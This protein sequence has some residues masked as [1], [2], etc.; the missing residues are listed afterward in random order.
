MRPKKTHFVPKTNFIAAGDARSANDATADTSS[1]SAIHPY[2]L[3]KKEAFSNVIADV[4]A[5]LVCMLK[6]ITPSSVKRA[7]FPASFSHNRGDDVCAGT[8][9]PRFPRQMSRAQITRRRLASSDHL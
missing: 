7:I 2:T 4:G 3:G 6:S 5:G 9:H 1:P 8:G